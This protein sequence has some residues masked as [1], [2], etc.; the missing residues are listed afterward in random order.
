LALIKKEDFKFNE[1][2]KKIRM[3][4]REIEENLIAHK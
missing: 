4:P 1:R 3:T 2:K